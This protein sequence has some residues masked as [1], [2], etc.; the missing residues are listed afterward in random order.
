MPMSSRQILDTIT[1]PQVSA[2]AQG[3]LMYAGRRDG[4]GGT[5][6]TPRQRQ[7]VADL[8]NVKQH[9]PQ[10]TAHP[11]QGPANQIRKPGPLQPAEVAWLQRFPSPVDPTAVAFQDAQALA[12]MASSVDVTKHPGDARLVSS[13]WRPVGDY[14]DHRAAQAA[15]ANANA[16]LPELPA[17][18]LGALADAIA[19]ETPQLTPEEA[20]GR[21]GRMLSDATTKRQTAR[22]AA[23]AAAQAQQAA[24]D[25]SVHTRTAVEGP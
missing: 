5:D 6:L 12:S 2:V 18:T 15:M 17:S 19:A 4:M 25:A 8:T 23:I 9:A 14:H 16:P 21:A 22:D 10:S 3:G 20:V 1:A 11:A 7:F 24:V 13:I